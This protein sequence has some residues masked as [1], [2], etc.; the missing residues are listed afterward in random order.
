[1]QIKNIKVLHIISSL[2]QGGA[3]RQLIE[4]VKK[5]KNHA[6]CQLI[7]GNMF[8]EEIKKN[9]IL[10]FNLNLKK[11][12][13]AIIR[14][15]KLF[16]IIKSYKPDIIN[17]WM[18]HSSFLEVV[19][20]KITFTNK[21]P[22]IWGLRCSNM[23]TH[24]YSKFLSFFIMG[25]KY[26]S[27][28]PNLIINNS[29]EGKKFHKSI[30]FK[31]KNIVIHNGIDTNKF[32]FNKAHRLQFRKKYKISENAKVLLCVGRYDPMKDHDTLIQAFKNVYK[33]FSSTFLIF[34]GS[35]TKNI[36]INGGII[37]LGICKDIEIVYSAS[38]III[39]SSAFGEGF[40]NA[41]AEGMSSSLIPIATDVGDS[42]LIVGEVGKVINPRNANELYCAIKE[43]LEMD[44]NVFL[45]NKLLARERIKQNFSIQKMV[46][47]YNDVYK[48]IKEGFNK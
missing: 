11:N 32:I 6:I 30:G 47:S 35:E 20:R 13:F 2:Q 46:S 23:E 7:D 19:L 16:K 33:T 28:I 14:L 10:T 22:L 21:I 43:L 1:M 36:K 31:N 39:S 34:A 37:T 41:L 27:T 25:C 24:Y 9:K 18:Y 4:L 40:S 45:K 48:N 15:Y 17:T 3:E 12:I 5:N 38:D 29:I 42:K 26:F 8:E 44:S